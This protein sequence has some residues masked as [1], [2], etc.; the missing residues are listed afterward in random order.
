MHS[1][2]YD[3]S[4]KSLIWR[5]TI[6]LVPLWNSI[7]SVKRFITAYT[8]KK[9]SVSYRNY[10]CGRYWVAPNTPVS[11]NSAVPGTWKAG[12]SGVQ[13][14]NIL[15]KESGGKKASFVTWVRGPFLLPAQPVGD[16][17][18][19]AE[20]GKS[21]LNSWIQL[22]VFSQLYHILCLLASPFDVYT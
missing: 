13:R 4:L 20:S 12:D 21:C 15:L 7:I 19:T 6:S 5:F 11:E 2:R 22:L 16:E 17:S 1:I 14:G 8:W 18:S 10:R 3:K 9:L